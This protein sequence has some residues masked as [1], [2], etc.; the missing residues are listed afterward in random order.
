MTRFA[1]G[2]DGCP[3]GWVVVTLGDGRL[4]DVEVVAHVD[5][6]LDDDRAPGATLGI[7]MPIGLTDAP[8]RAADVAARRLLPGRAS[9]IFNAPPRTVV[10]GFVDGSVTDHAT[11]SARSRATTGKGISQQA[12]RLVPK[13]AELDRA[14]AAGASMA[15]VHPEVAFAILVGE[16]LPRKRSWAG[17]TTRRGLLERHGVV[18]PERFPGDA[19]CAPDD[20]LDAAICAWVADGLAAGEP[21]LT[22][23]EPATEFDGGRPIVIHARRPPTLPPDLRAR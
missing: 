2:L 8:N 15:E 20:V 23:P 10:D 18:V 9:S 17:L 21:P 1:R 11:A 5:E 16:P 14:V 7:D 4:T 13:I 19:D 22:V 6:V 3:A 12:W